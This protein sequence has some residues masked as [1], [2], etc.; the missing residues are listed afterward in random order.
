MPR[1]HRRWLRRDTNDGRRRNVE[2]DGYTGAGGGT[3]HDT[4]LDEGRVGS[5]D[6]TSHT[7]P[8]GGRTS[9]TGGSTTT[10]GLTSRTTGG[11]SSGGSS[12]ASEATVIDI[13]YVIDNSASMADKQQVL[14]SSLPQFLTQLV[15][16]N[17]VNSTGRVLARSQVTSTGAVSPTL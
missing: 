3:S 12:G 11:S 8:T 4:S 10:G 6:A 1:G 14:A 16:P 17:C 13:L 9:S 2:S 7:A 5:F 15:Q